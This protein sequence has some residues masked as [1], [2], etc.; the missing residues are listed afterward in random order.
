MRT[1]IRADNFEVIWADLNLENDPEFITMRK[2]FD[3]ALDKLRAESS[4]K[5]KRD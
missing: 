3:E 2:E 1:G 5:E 4:Q